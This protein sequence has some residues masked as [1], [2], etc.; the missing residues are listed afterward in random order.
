MLKLATYSAGTVILGVAVAWV[1]T[2]PRHAD[3]EEIASF[4]PDLARGE[5][6]YT[7]GGCASCH[8][9]DD[10]NGESLTGGMAFE[11]AFGTFYA[12][13]IS[14]DP[15]QGIGT[16]SALNLADAMLH[17]TSP[18]GEHLYPAFPYTS[19]AKMDPADVVSLHAYLMTLPASTVPSK[20]HDVGFPFNI[21]RSLGGWKLLFGTSAGDWVVND[22]NMTEQDLQGRYLV[23]A[24]A[25]CAECHTPR[26]ALGGME[27]AKWLGGAPNPSGN[28]T[29]PN[30]TPGT[31]TWSEEDIAYYLESGFTPEYDSVGGHMAHVVD[32]FAALDA[33]DREA[34][35]SY[36]KRVAP[37][38]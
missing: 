16:W 17:G 7:A 30:I 31:L 2:E 24:L 37:V 12:P 15:D 34:V 9:G 14:P 20:A 1:L 11:S 3:L 26:N 4:T 6:V 29:I 8:A 27:T 25:H 38:E 36:L 33:S 22:P 19:Y 23:E 10:G 35:A 18:E 32:N 13:N 28:G 5:Y 21:R